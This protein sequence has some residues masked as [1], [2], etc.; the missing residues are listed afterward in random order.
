MKNAIK[1]FSED[2]KTSL[3]KALETDEIKEFV[4]KT[5]DATDSGTFEVIISTAD[6]DR[7]NESIDQKGWDLKNY[8][9]NPV[10]LWGHDYYSLPIGVCNS[11]TLEGDKL[12][13]KG[14]F[15]PADA[16]PF[17]QQVRKL[18]DAKIVRAT[19]VGFIAKE[20][21]DNVITKSELLEFS[22][23][24]VPANPFALS[25]AKAKELGLDVEMLNI[26]SVG[27]EIKE[28]ETEKTKAEGDTCTLEDGSEG[29]TDASGTCVAK[30]AAEGDKT[31]TETETKGAVAD[32]LTAEQTFEAKWVNI[33]AVYDIVDAFINAYLDETIPV[34][35][36]GS[37]AA[38]TAGLIAALNTGGDTSTNSIAAL[39]KF[40]SNQSKTADS[41]LSKIKEL[42]RV[43]AAGKQSGSSKS[44]EEEHTAPSSEE[45]VE[46][47]GQNKT[48]EE[49]DHFEL[50]RKVLRGINITVSDSL[51]RLNK[52]AKERNR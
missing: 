47:A 14:T 6:Y 43:G 18:Y 4:K 8:E 29:V 46:A 5:K 26:K 34:E 17:A 2:F 23:V 22:F 27:V 20:M 7:S 36:F 48:T 37:L 38:E 52:K 45:K 12:I 1:L 3:R 39:A 50:T 30:P 16:N 31:A 28:E 49:F 40:I 21:K 41:T 35:N 11:L 10:V 9:S 32:E 24:P 42:I 33:C 51:N 19:S 44:E 25:T 13:A 15:A